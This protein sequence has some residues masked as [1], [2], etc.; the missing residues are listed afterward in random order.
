MLRPLAYAMVLLAACAI[1]G[2]HAHRLAAAR[3]PT[4]RPARAQPLAMLAEADGASWCQDVETADHLTVVFFYAPWCRNCKAVRP[5]LQRIEKKYGDVSFFQ[6][7]FKTETELCYE[8]RVF[9]FPTVHFYL[10]GI[11]RVGRA[12]LTAGNTDAKML[13]LLDRFENGRTQLQRITAEAISPVVQYTELVSALQGLAEAAA[14][15]EI[16][17]TGFGAGVNPKKESAR[18]R[19]MV[20]GD[21]Q[22]LMELEGLFGSLDA[23]ADGRLQLGEIEAAAAALQPEGSVSLAASDLVE[24]LTSE[25]SERASGA[26]SVDRAT[27]VSL[28]VDK[29]VTDFAAGEKAL[30]PAFEAMDADGDGSISQAE[31]LKVIDNFCSMRPDADGCDIDHRPLRLAQAFNAFANE[32]QLLDY[33]RFVE[34]VSGR[35]DGFADQCEVGDEPLVR[36]NPL[37]DDLMGERECFGQ[38]ETDEGDDDLACDAWFYGEDPTQAKVEVVADPAKIAA[39]RAAGEA[40][41][42]QREKRE[43]AMAQFL[44]KGLSVKD[45][46]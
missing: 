8:Q 26:L 46:A 37:E 39:L 12:V 22:R 20:E 17:A 10:P 41:R 31:L 34:M 25:A 7:N 16:D 33:E 9:N 11:G 23:D 40:A 45:A 15:T 27:F 18:L 14:P 29:A 32:K 35:K 3:V 21:E 1:T 19:T 13:P 2:A 43:A 30:L 42:A 36:K 4:V 28:M 5:K 38:A 6:V 24:R 44:N